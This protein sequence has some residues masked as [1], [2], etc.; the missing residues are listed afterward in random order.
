MA[1]GTV[2]FFNPDKGFG[3]IEPSSSGPDIF[4]HI[5]ALAKAGLSVLTE[6]QM[7]NYT[8][9]TDEQSGKSTAVNLQLV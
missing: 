8:L 2:I 6:G 7:L 9:K 3:F 5:T 1:K 4:V